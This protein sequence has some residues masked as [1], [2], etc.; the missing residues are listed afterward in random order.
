MIINHVLKSLRSNRTIE[1][2]IDDAEPDYTI[3]KVG[4]NHLQ[5]STAEVAILFTNIAPILYDAA[6]KELDDNE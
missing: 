6:I 4:S 5:L 3:V 1:F 2:I